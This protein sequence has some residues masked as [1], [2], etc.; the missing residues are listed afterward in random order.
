MVYRLL[1]TPALENGE[2]RVRTGA[3]AARQQV[4]EFLSDLP[5]IQLTP[6]VIRGL[7]VCLAD[8]RLDPP[9]QR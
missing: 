6:S 3:Q 7:R 4:E 8:S 5:E 9:I 1:G 2:D